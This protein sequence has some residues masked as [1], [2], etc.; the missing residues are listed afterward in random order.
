MLKTVPGTIPAKLS[1]VEVSVA[2]IVPGH[3]QFV[4]RREVG[5]QV[6]PNPDSQDR[7]FRTL[8]TSAL[9][10]ANFPLSTFS[11]PL[12]GQDY[13]H[14]LGLSAVRH[15]LLYRWEIL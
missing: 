8:V 5:R 1:W 9:S 3:P 6:I 15:F 7:R 14:F 11:A 12:A 2:E 10:C 13:S 4:I